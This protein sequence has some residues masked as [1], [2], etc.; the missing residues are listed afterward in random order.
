MG[1]LVATRIG[2]IPWDT[3]MPHEPQALHNHGSQSCMRLAERGGLTPDEAVAVLED[4]PWK[5]MDHA[6]AEQRLEE[7]AQL[8]RY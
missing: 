5:R 1:W 3:I 7:L 6:E 4:R 8:T 2:H